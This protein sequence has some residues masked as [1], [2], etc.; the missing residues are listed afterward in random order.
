[1]VGKPVA[2]RLASILRGAPASAALYG[3]HGRLELRLPSSDRCSAVPPSTASR[4]LE[5]PPDERCSLSDDR[6][7]LFRE[8][9]YLVS[10]IAGGV[11]A[12]AC[13]DVRCRWFSHDAVLDGWRRRGPCRSARG[14]GNTS[15]V[16]TTIT[17]A[18]FHFATSFRRGHRLNISASTNAQGARMPLP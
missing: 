15:C 14:S 8:A 10:V 13:E 12:T 4:P 3:H 18:L 7:G 6:P 1:L 9:A 11:V 16:S 5:I 17:R 2:A